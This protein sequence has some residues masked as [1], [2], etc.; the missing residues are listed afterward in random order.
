MPINLDHYTPHHDWSESVFDD[1]KTNGAMIG[2]DIKDIYYSGFWS[3]GDGASFTGSYAYKAGA[4][5][6][7]RQ[8][9][10]KDDELHRIAIAL[11]AAQRPYFYKICATIKTSGRY[12]HS[13]AMDVDCEHIDDSYRDIGDCDAIVMALRSFA[14]WIYHNLE[15][16]YEYQ[17]AWQ[18]AVGWQ[19]RLEEAEEAKAEARKLVRDS[20]LERP[21]GPIAARSV[22][23]CIRERLS[24]WRAL[25][26]DREALAEAFHYR[27]DGKAID[28][29]TFAAE[30][31]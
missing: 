26:A 10:P 6:A 7:I 14:H 8:A 17:S 28:I 29:A 24:S 18:I 3:Q 5:K 27:Q 20:A 16:E 22:R 1:A 31:L 15:R 19:E 4:V 30:N 21:L 12:G 23:A 11:Q 9:A 2:I 25:L 13:G